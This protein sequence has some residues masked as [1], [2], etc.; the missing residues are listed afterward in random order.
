MAFISLP[1]TSLDMSTVE[2]GNYET[3]PIA[4]KDGVATWDGHTIRV[5]VIER[6]ECDYAVL[7]TGKHS[8]T[9]IES[10]VRPIHVESRYHI[11]D[12]DCI[13]QDLPW[14]THEAIMNLDDTQ[15]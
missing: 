3:Y 7:A 1:D 15:S 11:I 5:A 13:H 14:D 10:R 9:P 12:S 2:I 6:A 8:F 4:F